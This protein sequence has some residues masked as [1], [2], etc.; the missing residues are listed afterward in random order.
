L[1]IKNVMT[2]MAN[3]TASIAMSRLTTK[4]AT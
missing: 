1:K 2:E 3:S 4:R